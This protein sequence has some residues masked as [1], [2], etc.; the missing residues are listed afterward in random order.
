[1]LYVDPMELK[2]IIKI[3]WKYRI[4]FLAVTVSVMAVAFAWHFLLPQNYATSLMLNVTRSGTQQTGEYA[5]DDFYRLQ[6]DERFAD[7]VVRWLGDSRTVTDI[8]SSA[9][10]SLH[11]SESLRAKR[12]SSQMIS[13][14]FA[15]PN[16]EDAK[17]TASSIVDV[18]NKQTE[19]LNK[20][21][22]QETWFVVLGSE[23]VITVAGWPL[24]KIF[25]T[26]LLLGMFL[27]F[28][29][30]LGRHYFEK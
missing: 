23:P 8:Y 20:L 15:S 3:F 16:I 24:F 1:M 9:K 18:L 21:Q 30:V 14:T 29:T 5:Y 10:V 7:T 27:A 4:T 26:S 17:K 6:A 13:V 25:V 12:L 28:W 11:P 22:K 19:E 2:E